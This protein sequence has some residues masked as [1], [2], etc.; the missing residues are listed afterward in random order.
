[1]RIYACGGAG[2]NI[3]KTFEN[4]R[5]IEEAGFSLL[6]IAYIDA[7]SSNINS[8]KTDKENIYLLEDTFGNVKEGGGKKRRLNYDDISARASELILNYKP[9]KINIVMHSFH[10]GSGSVIGPVIVSNLLDKGEAVIVIGIGGTDS[11]IEI[12]N[13]VDTISSYA[14]ISKLRKKPVPCIYYENSKSTPRGMV[15]S[16]IIANIVMLSVFFSNGNHEMDYTDM[17]NFLNYN[18]VTDHTPKLSY[19]EFYTKDIELAKDTNIISVATLSDA[20]TPTH[21]GHSVDY[22]CVGFISNEVKEKLKV[23]MPIHLCIIDG[24]FSDIV[25]RLKSI[26]TEIEQKRNAI[27]KKNMDVDLSNTTDDGLVI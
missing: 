2:I 9:E 6:N 14:A 17:Y 27:V 20:S 4:H 24:V 21:P 11:N 13:T 16:K 15:D 10:G 8:I 7:S 5:G 26:K 19:M 18:E 22:Q 12:S 1:M 25:H 23:E 3:A